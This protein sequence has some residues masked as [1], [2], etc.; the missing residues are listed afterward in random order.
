MGLELSFTQAKYL[1]SKIQKL[2][3][4]NKMMDVLKCPVWFLMLFI[5]IG[6]L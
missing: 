5:L 2:E 4:F 6:D 3:T 1:F